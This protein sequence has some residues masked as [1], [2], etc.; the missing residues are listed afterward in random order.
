M[1]EIQLQQQMKVGDDNGP[2]KWGVIAV[3]VAGDQ[4]Y[5]EREPFDEFWQLLDQEAE[6]FFAAVAAKSEPDPA[7]SPVEIPWLA[8]LFPTVK[9]K[10]LDLSQ[11]VAAGRIAEKVSRYKTLAAQESGARRAKEMLRAELLALAKDNE[12]VALPR[13]IRFKISTRNI[14]EQA[15][16]ASVS[17]T[18]TVYVPQPAGAPA[19][20]AA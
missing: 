4:Y 1:H 17:K 10:M 3:W 18:L 6:V 5:F 8:R 14:A 20:S 2:Y 19:P 13:G 15:R 12:E 7:G 11:D 9:A 16:K